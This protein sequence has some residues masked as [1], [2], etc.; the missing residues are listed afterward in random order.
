MR[1]D[2]GSSPLPLCATSSSSLNRP[3]KG[4][5]T[6]TSAASW[7]PTTA[8]SPAPAASFGDGRGTARQPAA[9]T[10]EQAPAGGRRRC[11]DQAE[12]GGDDEACNSGAGKARQGAGQAQ[13]R[14]GLLPR[15]TRKGIW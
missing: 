2:A 6:A 4:K 14:D 1:A 8:T 15:E 7:F 3:R 11:F 10:R 9:G 13:A 5:N 12:G